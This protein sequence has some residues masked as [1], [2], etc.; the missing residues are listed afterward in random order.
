MLGVGFKFGID[1][2]EID[3]SKK[4]IILN[5][6]YRPLFHYQKVFLDTFI[7]DNTLFNICRALK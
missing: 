2:I 4:K 1:S 3:F 7:V 6:N 5:E